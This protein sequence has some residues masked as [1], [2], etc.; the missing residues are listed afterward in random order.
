MY[1]WFN[2]WL[3]LICSLLCVHIM[4][5]VSWKLTNAAILTFLKFYI[6]IKWKQSQ[7]KGGQ[8]LVGSSFINTLSGLQNMARET[9][10]CYKPQQPVSSR[11]Y[12]MTD[13]VDK[14]MT[15]WFANRHVSAFPATVANEN[16]VEGAATLLQTSGI[17]KMRPN[18]LMVGF[19]SKWNTDGVANLEAI[20]GYYEIILNA[21]EKNV[22]VAIF[23]N[24]QIGFDLTE[25]L[26]RNDS[27]NSIIDADENG[28]NT[29]P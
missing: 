4:L 5:A 6:Y 15:E 10:L 8:K 29:D 7:P 18:I 2:R 28:I 26:K 19:K 3:A 12:L 14:Q 11:T 25:H 20:M 16:Q 21:F 24:S 22:G 13:K 1:R 27:T 23:R 9:D 17:G